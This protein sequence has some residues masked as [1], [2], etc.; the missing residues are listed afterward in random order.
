MSS[1]KGMSLVNQTTQVHTIMR[2]FW[3]GW[4]N[5][6]VDGPGALARTIKRIASHFN[7]STD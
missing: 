4:P 3:D 7:L 5:N 2:S 1:E 6:I